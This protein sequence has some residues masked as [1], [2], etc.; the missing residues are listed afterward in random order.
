MLEQPSTAE[1]WPSLHYEDWKDTLETLHMWTQIV[2]KI[3]LAHEPMVNH[4][5][6]VTLYVTSRGL[7]TGPMPC[8]GSRT[9]QIDFDFLDHVLWI[10]DCNS[11]R[12]QIALRPMPVAEFYAEV[13]RRLDELGIPT[14][15]RAIPNEVPDAIPFDED[16][17]HASYDKE[18]VH[19]FWRVLVQADR[20]CKAFRGRFVGK[21]SP[22]HFFWGAFD[23]AVTRFSGRPAPPHPGGFPNIPDWVMREAYSHEVSSCGFWPGGY[24]VDAVFYAYAY[25]EPEGFAQAQ[26]EPP[27]AYYNTQ[28]REFMLPYEAVR[29]SANP[30][31]MVLSFFQ[32]TYEAAADLA[33]WDRTALERR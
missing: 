28:L 22:T 6:Q 3:R 14:K 12:S 5:W 26:A 20:L 24:G 17:T 2:G 7:T 15:I 18:Y 31:D 13:L 9:F 32:T 27:E 23:L 1:A 10:A 25:P 4:W 19:R 8:T 21:D 29:Q 33:G 11:A 30:D 16:Y